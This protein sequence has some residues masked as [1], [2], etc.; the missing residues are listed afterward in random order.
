MEC[1]PVKTLPEGPAWTY[2]VKLDGFRLEAVKQDGEVVLYSRR[3]NV[4]NKKFQYIADA[5]KELPDSTILDGEIVALDA[6]NRSDFSLLQNF[7]SAETKIHYYAFDALMHKGK[8][9][10]QQPLA[11]RRAIL[12]KI[13]P[14]NEHVSLSVFDSG[15]ARRMVQFVRKQGL[16]GVIAKREDSLYEPGKRSGLWSKYRINLG[17]EFVIGGYTPGSNGF[18]ALIIGFYRGKEFLFAARVRAG[19]IPATRKDVYKRIASLKITKCPF[20]NLPQKEA[21]RWGQGLTAEKMKGCVWLKPKAVARFDFLEWTGADHL[22]HPKFVAM[23][24]D[25]D[26]RQVVRET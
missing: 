14:I 3:G 9:L 2:E 4:L 20:A 1:L 24:D 15:S 18:D 21:G 5:L 6:D 12:E 19:F 16:E 10:T 25:K 11:E 8:P 23:R 22:R 13:L 26:P 7:R 17:H